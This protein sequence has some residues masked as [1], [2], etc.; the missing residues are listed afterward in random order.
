MQQYPILTDFIHF[1]K[2]RSLL[3][4]LCAFV[5]MGGC[6]AAPDGRIFIEEA[7]ECLCP[8][9][10]HDIQSTDFWK[11]VHSERFLSGNDE[12]G[13][14]R[15]VL[16]CKNGFTTLGAPI[17]IDGLHIASIFLG[18]FL[19][20]PEGHDCS[21]PL[22]SSEQESNASPA[23]SLPLVA[24][25]R[26][27]PI[28]EHL[29]IFVELI[30]EMG[31]NQ[32]LEKRASDMSAHRQTELGPLESELRDKALFANQEKNRL[33]TRESA[34]R[35]LFQHAPFGIAV[36]RLADGVFLDVNPALVKQTRRSIAEILGKS[37]YD[38]LPKAQ[39]PAAEKVSE[40]LLEKGFIGLQETEV[41]NPDGSTRSVLYSAAT[42]KSGDQVNV[43]SMVI[44]ITER[45]E[46]ERRLR[47]S[48][49]RM[50]S[51]YNAV[52]VG[53]AVL[54]DRI[55][56]SVNERLAEITGYPVDA[57][58][59][60]SSRSL[61]FS[62]EDFEAVGKA[63]YRAPDSRGRGYKETRF[64][65]KDGSARYISLFAAPLE[66]DN[67]G[68]GAVVAVQD[69]T[70]QKAMLQALRDSEERFRSIMEQSTF[71]MMILSPEGKVL[72]V[73]EACLRLWG[74]CRELASTYNIL[75]DLQLEQLGLN[76]VIRRA[77]AGEQVSLP[78]TTYDLSA[79]LGEGALRTVQADFYP[80]RDVDGT[81]RHIILI[82]QDVTE[83]KRAEEALRLNEARLEALMEL[84]Q[85]RFTSLNE[86]AQFAMDAAVRL[87]QSRLGYIGFV[88]EEQTELTL[89]AWSQAAMREC[90]IEDKPL[91]Y[92]LEATGLWGET[93]RQRRPVITND[94]GAPSP[95]KRGYPEGHVKLVR[96]LGVPV[97][98]GDRVVMMV[99]V[100]NKETDYDEADVRQLTLLMTGMWQILQRK[101]AK[102]A[103]HER[104][105]RL[106]QQ[107]AALL[108]LMSRGTLFQSDLDQAVA[109]IIEASSALI[110]TERVS[111][112]LYNEDF[113]D[114]RC[115]DL[116]RQSVGRHASGE[117]LQCKEFPSYTASHRK[118]EVI[119]AVDVYTDPR[120]QD[121]PAAYYKE[122]DI[123][124]LLDAPV[125]LHDRLGGLLSFEH[126][127]ERRVWT[128]E[129]ERLASNMAALLTL[130]FE[131]DERKKAQA[132]LQKS[133]SQ[134]ANAVKIAKLGHWELDIAS[135]VFIFTD[136]L[137][138][139]LH[140]T[141]KDVGGYQMSIT[142]YAKHFVHP[143]DAWRVTEELRKS[144]ETDDP[145]FGCQLETSGALR[146]WWHRI[147]SG[148][149]LCRQKSLW[150]N[151]QD[152]WRQSRYHRAQTG[153][154]S[155][156]GKWTA[157]QVAVRG[158]R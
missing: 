135:G 141:A 118:G 134:L 74:I 77:M 109:E 43:V 115:I 123:R 158:G 31:R 142:E 120:T 59:G 3:K 140:T 52:P 24:P 38:F 128:P 154:N 95:W 157:I 48:E 72:Y 125:W 11:C 2:L 156:T 64:R 15:R 47:Q 78:A 69:I 17:H 144:I 53:L 58:L 98:D 111:V 80:A 129:D 27:E 35:A 138:D 34:W 106:Q 96:H 119:A 71:S 113:A 121:I 130:C 100:G 9:N 131:T 66:P 5:K 87:T 12:T 122:H 44:D 79:T 136:S 55:I 26:I 153:R 147:H 93:F 139:I 89:Y 32:L 25:E 56:L 148:T 65:H 91:V 133:E 90:R 73:N 63:L 57:L 6:I 14:E 155:R 107:N 151:D 88:N 76:P 45:K 81:V 68:E 150:K 126:V 62:D 70:E 85:R 108:R 51:L 92:R 21:V 117:M 94:Y 40:V 105:E 114:I 143:E 1:D 7:W 41:L 145:N 127:G 39:R 4:K 124:S 82:Q 46:M 137:Y 60:H 102:K 75:T 29:D 20:E 19:Q 54:K 42:F 16:V 22:R 28:I 84:N 8:K 61:Y 50:Q 132:A 67:P 103:L 152:L 86:M 110:N 104:E 112:W 146:R 116:Y 49:A 83:R 10:E 99:G 33:E 23:L 36:N 30:A 18:P 149:L 13:W 37:S 97:L 101:Q